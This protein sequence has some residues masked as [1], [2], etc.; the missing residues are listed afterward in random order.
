MTH[1]AIQ[2]VRERLRLLERQYKQFQEDT[3]RDLGL[4]DL[5]NDTIATLTINEHILEAL[6]AGI[7]GVQKQLRYDTG[8]RISARQ[9]LLE[10][11]AAL[12]AQLNEPQLNYQK[13][14]REIELWEEKLRDITG[15][16]EAPETLRGIETRIAQLDILPPVL[17]ERQQQ[18]LTLTGEIFD[19]LDGQRKARE[20]LFKPV[21]DLI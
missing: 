10:E 16:P 15:T 6:D 2:S 17:L 14:L 5:Q 19:I 12:N 4:L 3:A 13:N 20:A 7:P 18:R 21:Q 9:S 1:R 8:A 11:Q